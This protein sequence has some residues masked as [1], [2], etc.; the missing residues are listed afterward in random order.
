MNLIVAAKAAL[1]WLEAQWNNGPQWVPE[2]KP[3]GE[4]ITAL[5]A[6]IEA[7][8][9]TKPVATLHDDGCFTWKRDEF[10]RKFDRQ[11]AGWRMDVYAS[12]P[13]PVAL[14]TVTPKTLP[15][16]EW[17]HATLQPQPVAATRPQGQTLKE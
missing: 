2:F 10:R 7:A 12:P 16:S 15:E 11:R 14:M 4:V 13:Q 3:L 1:P 5:R 9:K 6:A 8:E 17:V